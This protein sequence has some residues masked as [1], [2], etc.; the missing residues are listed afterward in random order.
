MC[1]RDNAFPPVCP[2]QAH[3]WNPMT[4]TPMTG[5]DTLRAIA[6]PSDR[7]SVQDGRL[8]IAGHDA[9]A[10]LDAFGSPLYV[11]VEDTLR[12]NY[13]R[14]REAFTAAWPAPVTVMY[15]VKSNNTLAIRRLLSQEGAGGDCFGLGELQACLRTGTNPA[16][17]VLNG[18]NK[19]SAELAAA[20]AH[21]IV[22]NID[23]VQE[24]GEIE[25]LA[26]ARPDGSGRIRVNLRLKPLPAGIDAFSGEFFKT[27]DSM[28]EAVRRTKWGHSAPSAVALIE[29]IV[30]SPL[31]ELCGY[32]SHIGRFSAEPD[33]FATVAD[34]LGQDVVALFEA[35]GYWPAMLDIGGG[36]PRQREPESRG[37]AMNP[38]PIETYATRTADALRRALA[39]AGRRLPDLWL[40]P[41]RYLVGNGV[42]LLAT[43]GHV[44]QDLGHIWTHVDAS[45][46]NLMRV[47]T[48]RAW[49]HMLPA[50]R[51]GEPMDTVMDIVGGTCI[52]SV[53]GASR[54]M[55]ALAAGD[56]VA[57]LDAGMYA[58]AISNQFN[59][60]GR[61]ATVLV[62]EGSAQI[63]KRRET[64]EDVFA[65]HVIPPH[66]QGD[67]QPA[68]PS[69]MTKEPT[70]FA[71][72]ALDRLWG[73]T[74]AL[75]GEV[76]V[77]RSQLR[78]LTGATDDTAEDADAFVR[79]LLQAATAPQ[80]TP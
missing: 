66:L 13:R 30:A 79:H 76:F 37:A 33:A 43:A 20:I 8:R 45:T 52:P 40:E 51:M 63:I 50:T 35:T 61:P 48:S 46:N 7:L 55:P 16:R 22:I 31:L 71:D 27:A 77:L 23:A 78:R 9:A 10:L 54:P 2:A 57:I 70:F 19:T 4:G 47:D 32:S 28:L 39:P 49:H 62:S 58:E 24:I 41:G 21:D 74:T 65:H 53:L 3:D 15:A 36:W 72:P 6:T 42:V 59:S 67:G 18:S 38:H 73:V 12:E 56:A 14:I 60:L 25:E 5:A 11:A 68:G 75:A 69:R 26:R 1:S 64:I 34:A 29:R 80:G 44:K 17:M